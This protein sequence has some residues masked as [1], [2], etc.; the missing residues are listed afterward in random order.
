MR[1]LRC[2]VVLTLFACC[3][4]APIGRASDDVSSKPGRLA[5]A[6][7][8]CKYQTAIRNQGGRD[9]CPY[10]PPVAAL[11]A[12]YCRAGQKV[13]LSAEHLIWL[14]NVTAG[15]DNG[16]RDVAENLI[17]TLGGGN[18]MGVL[19]TY[20]VCRNEDLPY[21]GN[22][23]EA[24]MGRSPHYKGFGLEEY[25][26]SKPFS[27][28]VLNRWNLDPR[29]LPPQ[30]RANAKYR[31][32]KFA[33]MPRQD[34]NNPRKFEEILA[35]GREIIFAVM[36][37]RDIHQVDPAQPVWRRKPGSPAF[38]YH[39]MLVVGYDSQRRFFVVKNQWGPADYSVNKDRLAPGWKDIVRYDGYTLMDY[40]YLAGCGEAHYI[41]E[42]TPVESP[43]HSAQRA[44]GQ[45]ALTFKHK[46]QSLMTGVLCWRRL[47]DRPAGVKSNRR[48]GDLVTNDGR[49]FRVNADLQGDGTKPYGATLYIDFAKGALPAASTA[50]TT[51]KGTLT[52][53]EKGPA[54]LRLRGTS[55]SK[56]D[57]WDVPVAEIQMSAMLVED[58]NLLKEMTPP[59]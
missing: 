19:N 6:M 57:L 34:V 11:E 49:Q 42:V 43:S 29:Q 15:G 25:D 12:A 4:L 20:S 58:R 30:A 53:P 59:K 46:D 48:I 26:W 16:K 22:D 9:V 50:G 10:F 24:G 36:L 56:Q 23:S 13:D 35:S 52:L 27:Q 17:S 32:E 47:P 14:R 55:D 21:R 18:G 28:F 38:G 51:W 45:W 2:I 31:I 39:F 3:T 8:L 37:H 44:L 41:T 1:P 7:D 54:S 5:P 33:S 40:N